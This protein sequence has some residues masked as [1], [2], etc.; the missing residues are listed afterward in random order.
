M[1]RQ[2][3]AF[4]TEA[5]ELGWL[6]VAGTARGVC[7]L[8]LGDDPDALREELA[9]E[10]PFAVFEPD[11]GRLKAWTDAVR[12]WLADPRLPLDV[13]LDVSGS[14][15]QRRVWEA[16]RSIPCGATRSYADLA[17]AIGRPRAVRAVAGACAA[18][19]VALVVPCHRV[20]ARQGVG[21]YRYG[22]A[23]K[24]ALLARERRSVTGDRHDELAAGSARGDGD[25][26]LAPVLA[27]G[28]RP[29]VLVDLLLADG[30]AGA[31]EG[32]LEVREDLVRR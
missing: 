23:R 29:V 15:F 25:A 4:R 9:G 13:P 7:N 2:A 1:E 30:P 18:N 10:F 5:C 19:P 14:R 8:R 22:V 21:G 16:I 3:I 27:G 20:V 32:L 11:G 26:H 12:A 28:Q 17:R 31:G 6:L 24:R